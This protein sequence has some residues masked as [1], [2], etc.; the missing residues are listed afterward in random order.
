MSK[1]RCDLVCATWKKLDPDGCGTLDVEQVVGAYH[2]G[3]HPG[4]VKGHCT[5]EEAFSAF[6]KMWDKDADGKVTKDEFHNYM[7]VTC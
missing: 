3:K 4:V 1:A 2:A 7:E 5:A 6:V